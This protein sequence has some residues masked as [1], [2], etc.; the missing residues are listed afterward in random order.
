MTRRGVFSPNEVRRLV[1]PAIWEEASN[2]LDLVASV[3]ERA[4]PNEIGVS[5]ELAW[6]SRAELRNY[7]HHQLLRDTDVMS[8]AHSLE[9]RVPLLDRQLVSTVLGIPSWAKQINSPQPKPLLVH[10]MRGLL[11]DLILNRQ[12]KQG[13]TFPFAIWLRGGL[14]DKTRGAIAKAVDAGIVQANMTNVLLE[15]FNRGRIHW[16]RIWSLAALSSISSVTR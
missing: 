4:G 12:D 2:R 3:S 7:T 15:Q 16:S 13:F 14:A 1:S 8:M 10:A 9:V 11:P 6:V 5:D